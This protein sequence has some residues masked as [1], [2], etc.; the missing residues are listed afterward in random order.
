MMS[1]HQLDVV[2]ANSKSPHQDED[3]VEAFQA[4]VSA[5]DEIF[6]TSWR[7][8]P[9]HN[10]T[11]NEVFGDEVSQQINAKLRFALPLDM[12]TKAFDPSTTSLSERR[13]RIIKNKIL[14]WPLG[15]ALLY[16]PH[17]IMEKIHAPDYNNFINIVRELKPRFVNRH[18]ASSQLKE[19]SQLR[20]KHHP[21]ESDVSLLGSVSSGCRKR[22]GT[23]TPAKVPQSKRA[24]P[25][26]NHSDALLVDALNKQVEMF[27]KLVSI[28][29]EQNDNLKKL[30][31][32]DDPTADVT[33]NVE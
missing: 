23:S 8:W 18:R 9:I 17:A 1:H 10:Y 22:P 29:T 12:I 28:S 24:A 31:N 14:K 26:Q 4:I 20:D 7:S 30:L 19:S 3:D 2:L 16:A 15:R 21:S 27:N 32:R 11:F 33:E 6:P 13:Y 25:A 5:V